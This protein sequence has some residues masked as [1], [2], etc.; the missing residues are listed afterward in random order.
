M[1][2]RR[3]PRLLSALGLLGLALVLLLAFATGRLG[4]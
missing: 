3:L 4:I 2:A 1:K